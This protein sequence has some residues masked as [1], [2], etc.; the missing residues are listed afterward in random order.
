MAR[1]VVVRE[2]PPSA[3]IA[4]DYI[5]RAMG[6]GISARAME[7]IIRRTITPISRTTIN[8]VVRGIKGIQ[9][10]AADLRFLKRN[11]TPDPRRIR[12]PKGEILTKYSFTV[13][14]SGQ[15]LHY[16]D[17]GFR[18]TQVTSDTLLTREQME[19]RASEIVEL[20]TGSPELQNRDFV[21]VEA[22]SGA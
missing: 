3:S 15:G 22:L 7:P 11:A 8:N 1:P 12:P 14:S 9:E 6:R 17:D 16:D 19:T 18:Y 10:A 21:V 20:K 13:R 4:Y 5:K 2:M